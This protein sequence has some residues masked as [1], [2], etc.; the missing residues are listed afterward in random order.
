M[1]SIKLF[2]FYFYWERVAVSKFVV[3]S[4]AYYQRR[5]DEGNYIVYWGISIYRFLCTQEV[6]FHKRRFRKMPS[7]CAYVYEWWTEKVSR[8]LFFSDYLMTCLEFIAQVF[9]KRKP[10][11]YLTKRPLFFDLLLWCPQLLSNVH[12]KHLGI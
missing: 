11:T 5:S 8:A 4:M 9:G 7:A 12:L 3:I 2:F 1:Q 6:H 10:F